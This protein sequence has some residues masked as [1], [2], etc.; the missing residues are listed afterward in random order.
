[1]IPFQRV[2]SGNQGMRIPSPETRTGILQHTDFSLAFFNSTSRYGKTCDM[3]ND[4]RA[5][6]CSKAGK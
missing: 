1:M 2:G 5:R 4:R 3:Q 6:Y